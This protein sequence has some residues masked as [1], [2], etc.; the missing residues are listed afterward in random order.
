MA[1]PLSLANAV[2]TQR[3]DL[4]SHHLQLGA[5]DNDGGN[6]ALALAFLLH[7][8]ALHDR[9]SS[10]ATAAT[11]VAFRI[12]CRLIRDRRITLRA[13]VRYGK[14]GVGVTI[15]EAAM[16]EQDSRTCDF[17]GSVPTFSAYLSAYRVLRVLLKREDVPCAVPPCE[18]E[19]R[20][21]MEALGEALRVDDSHYR[22]ILLLMANVAFDVRLPFHARLI[23][24][25]G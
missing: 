8:R 2:R 16:S 12:L 20:V 17:F 13:P 11:T 25:I 6:G 10:G 18:F 3:I 19:R 4:V 21:L 22:L 1:L 23:D 7:Q 9:P 14:G 5:L 24:L 15:Y